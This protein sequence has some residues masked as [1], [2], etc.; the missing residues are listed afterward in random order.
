MHKT[1]LLVF[2]FLYLYASCQ[3]QVKEIQASPSL[4]EA[5]ADW[6]KESFSLPPS[7]APSITFAGLEEVR[8]APGWFDSSSIQFWTYSFAWYIEGKQ[9]LADKRL[10][11]LT[12]DYFSGLSQ[13]VGK[14]NGLAAEAIS[15]ASASFTAT[16]KVDG[17]QL[18]EGNVTF[19]DVFF[20]RKPIQLHIKVKES[21][22]PQVDKHLLVFSSS[23]QV[24]DHQVWKIFDKVRTVQNCKELAQ[25]PYHTR[26]HE[27]YE[28]ILPKG[29]IHGI[30]ILFPGFGENPA[31]IQSEFK[32]V[33]PAIKQGFAIA[34]MKNNQQL[35]LQEEEKSQLSSLLQQV[36]KENDIK[37]NNVY[38]GGFSSGGNVALLLSNYLMKQETAVKPKGGFII[39]SPVDLLKLYENAQKNVARNFSQVSVGESKMLV[40]LLETNFGKPENG[41]AKYEKHSVYTTRTSNI[42][43][44]SQLKNVKI[45]LYTEPDT[46]WWKQ[47]R[48]NDYEETNAYVIKSLSAHLSKKF[49][50]TVEYIPT[51]NRGYRMNGARHPHSWSIVEVDALLKWMRD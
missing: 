7:F 36:V 5:P 23:P 38:I 39:D 9:A 48:G 32:I 51:Q 24:F 27:K 8:F 34:L 2:Y 42:N 45:R 33:D 20:S 19:T 14:I 10:Q 46:L 15:K 40:D 21:Y 1:L 16:N 31:G 41:I 47:N 35:W 43:N 29:K 30:L 12:E 28:L 6:G 11:Q 49:G 17:W 37:N 13:S 44:V 25:T 22:C 50:H 26:Y 3:A 18:F 4:L